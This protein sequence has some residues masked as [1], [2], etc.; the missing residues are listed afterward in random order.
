MF[1]EAKF[2]QGFFSFSATKLA[3]TL[4]IPLSGSNSQKDARR[5]P[6]LSL[7]RSAP[8]HGVGFHSSS[9]LGSLSH[10]VLRLSGQHAAAPAEKDANLSWAHALLCD[11]YDPA[12]HI[13]P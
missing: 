4:F 8:P 1:L 10:S 13:K 7:I 9:D 2:P 12:L 6:L 3:L 11:A 5:Q